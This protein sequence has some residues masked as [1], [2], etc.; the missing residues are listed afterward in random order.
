MKPSLYLIPVPISDKSPLII[1]SQEVLQI[2]N[3]I[4]VFIVEN[5]NT[6]RKF[7]KR[8]G[9]EINQYK[10]EFYILDE[11]TSESELS[12]LLLPLK[13]GR[14]IGLM[15]EA[16]MPALADPGEDFIYLA[17]QSGFKVIPL[18]GPSSIIMA[19][20]ASG[21]NGQ[22]FAFNGYLPVK[23]NDRVR[24]IKKLEERIYREKQTQIFM[25]TPYRNMAL[26]EDLIRSCN[27][28]TLLCIATNISGDDEFILTKPIGYWKKK[29]PDIHKKPTVFIL[30]I[31]TYNQ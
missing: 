13:E 11:H 30:G 12:G 2:L 19:L 5:I 20:I 23:K 21:L 29:L 15:S 8:A 9:V 1:L 26:L 4:D 17:H 31:S 6:A 22:N 27:P 14:D 16:G 7:L 18:P 25:E 10:P 28:K 24:I 3:S